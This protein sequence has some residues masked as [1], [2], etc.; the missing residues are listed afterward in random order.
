[1]CEHGVPGGALNPSSTRYPD[2]GHCG[3]LPL[4]GK[5]PTA[6]PG[7]ELGILWLIDRSSDQQATRLVPLVLIS[8]G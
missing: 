3:D 5:I 1:M 7:V 6:E 4:Q 8:T 2:H